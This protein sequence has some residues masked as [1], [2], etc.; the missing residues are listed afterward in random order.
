MKKLLLII[1]SCFLLSGCLI[2]TC[3][4]WHY[5]DVYVPGGY[6]RHGYFFPG[7]WERILVCDGYCTQ[8]IK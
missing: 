5:Q 8:E 7:H 2:T 1:A 4:S 3:C 6:S